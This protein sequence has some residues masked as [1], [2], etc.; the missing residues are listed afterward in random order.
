MTT[1]LQSRLDEK[2]GSRHRE[3]MS[4]NE[5]NMDRE[6]SLVARSILQATRRHDDVT[7]RHRGDGARSA[8]TRCRRSKC[9]QT[10]TACSWE[11]P[12][13]HLGSMSSGRRW[14][15][16]VASDF[17]E[18][19]VSKSAHECDDADGGCRLMTT[20]NPSD[21]G[22]P[23]PFLRLPSPSH[24][25]PRRRDGRIAPPSKS[26]DFRA[27]RKKCACW[28]L[29]RR[30]AGRRSVGHRGCR[31]AEGHF[32][33]RSERPPLVGLRRSAFR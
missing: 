21:H 17:L 16:S 2:R 25:A 32:T 12:K 27:E 6:C 13:M 31:R 5:G 22:Q 33:V 24:A 19:G 9:L 7:A 30:R 4:S 11:V 10:S 1:G 26:S 28:R 20:S 29:R 15:Y 3:S 8:M 23:G 14:A 18:V